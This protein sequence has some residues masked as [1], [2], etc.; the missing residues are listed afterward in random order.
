[1]PTRLRGGKCL[2]LVT[3]FQAVEDRTDLEE[4]QISLKIR[5]KWRIAQ[6]LGVFSGIALAQQAFLRRGGH[7]LA[8]PGEQRAAAEGAAGA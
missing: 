3:L 1:M 2:G 4:G 8:I 5:Q 6:K 7:Q